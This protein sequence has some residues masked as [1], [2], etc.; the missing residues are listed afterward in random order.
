M[1]ESESKK[2]VYFFRFD[3]QKQKRVKTG[4][5]TRESTKQPEIVACQYT[6][7]KAQKHQLR[8]LPGTETEK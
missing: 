3:K 4:G 7:E 6:E 2:H 8:L 1:G 5:Q